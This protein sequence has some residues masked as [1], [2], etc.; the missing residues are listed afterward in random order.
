[1]PANYTKIKSVKVDFAFQVH[2]EYDK[3]KHKIFGMLLNN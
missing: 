1:M 2:I 3:Q